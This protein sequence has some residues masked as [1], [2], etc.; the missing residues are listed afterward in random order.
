MS[1]NNKTFAT[2]VL[3]SVA[4]VMTITAL[5]LVS[6]QSSWDGALLT[7]LNLDSS[8]AA[9]TAAILNTPDVWSAFDAASDV[10][11]SDWLIPPAF[12]APTINS[13]NG[14]VPD[15]G[16]VNI[17][18][19]EGSLTTLSIT[20][21]S[22]STIV[23]DWLWQTGIPP[24]DLQGLN[25]SAIT[26]TA[27]QV[28]EDV[29]YYLTV[30]V[31]D[32]DTYGYASV[33]IDLTVLDADNVTNTAPTV[34]AGPDLPDATRGEEIELSG[35]TATDAETTD[36]LTYLWTVNPINAVTFVNATVLNPTITV[37]DTA[38]AG[39][40][41]LTLTVNDGT[42]DADDTRTF[43]VTVSTNTPPNVDAGPDLPDATRGDEI[44]LTE[45]TATDAETT[46][47]L[48]Y[49]WTVNPINAVTFVNATVLNPTITVADDATA[50]LVTLTLTV[51]DGTVDV[52][53]MRTFTVQ[54]NV[55]VNAEPTIVVDNLL[56]VAIGG[57][58]SPNPT[59][60][61]LD[62]PTDH[63]YTWTQS[64]PNTVTFNN[65]DSLMTTITAPA[66]AIAGDVT[67]T[68]T[69][70]DGE[71]TVEREITLTI[72]DP[73]INLAPTVDVVLSLT[74]TDSITN[75]RNL[76]L[77][78]ATGITTF[79]SDGHIYAAVAADANDG[80]QIL[81]VTDPYNIIAA[82][83]IVSDRGNAMNLYNAVGITTFKLDGH[84]YAAVATF[85]DSVQILNVTNPLNITATDSIRDAGILELN[86]A[87]DIT[88]FKSGGHTYAAVAAYQDHGV[89]ILNVTNPLNITPTD[90]ITNTGN[91]TLK[92]ARGVT[93]F[94]SGGHTYAAVAAFIDNGVQ[95]LNVTNPSNITA[96]DRILDGGSLELEG[97]WGITTFKS[98]GHIYAAVAAYDDNGVQILNVTNP[99]NI[100][101]AG[102]IT[103]TDLDLRGPKDITTF[104]SGGHTYAAVALFSGAS[105]Q[106]LDVTNPYNITAVA[107]IISSSNTKLDGV[108]GIATFESRGYTYMVVASAFD[109]AVQIIRANIG[110]PVITLEGDNPVTISV[111]VTY[112]DKGATCTD[113]IEGIITMLPP[114]STVNT[115]S[116]GTYDVTYSCV[117]GEGNHA[118]DVSRRVTVQAESNTNTPP[119]VSA[120]PDREVLE[121][122][123]ITLTGATATDPD[124]DELTY[125][126]TSDPTDAV[127]FN[128]TENS[129]NPSVTAA[130]G[131]NLDSATLTL[132]VN[133]G[134][135]D[136]ADDMM[137]TLSDVAVNNPPIVEAGPDR[138]VLEGE[139]ITLTGATAT[140]P[141]GDELTYA[142][143]SDPT[144]AVNFNNTENSLNPSVTAAPGTNLDSA[145]LTLTV[146]DGFT[147]VADDMMLTL[148]DVAVNNPPIVEAGPDREVLEGESITLTGATATDPDGDELTYAWTSDPTDAVNFNNT[149]N[150]L[151]PSVTA[152]PGTNLD[153]ATLTLTV[154]DGFTDV[155]DDMMLTLSDVAVNNPPIVEAGPDR[156]VLEGE[157]IT[158]TGATA[159]DPD[160][161]EL[162]YAWTSDPTDAVNFNNTEN[163]LNPSVTAAPGTN[164]DSAT[165][166]LTVNDG[167]TDVAD[168]MML[169]LSDVAVNNPPIVEAGPDREVL[170]G[171]SI[172]L[173]GATATDPDGDELTY[174]WTSDPTDAVNFNNTEN[175]LNPSVTAA[176]GTNLD[177][178]TLTLTVNDGFTDVADDM[179][180]TLSDVAVN[181][182]PIVEAG[183]DREVLEGES[184]TLT[185][186]TATD[187]DGDELTYAWT[188]DPT[189][190]VNFNNTENSLNPSVTAAP[191]TNLDSATLTLTVNDG[192]TDVADDMMLTLSD[193][194]VNNPPIVEAGPDREVLEGE[195][196]TLTGATA[197]DPDGD[198]LTYAWTSD[199]TDAVNFNNTE[200][201]LNPSVTAA[202]GT[203][204][205]SATLTLTVNDGFT[206]VADDMMLTL[207]DVAVNNP[208]IVEAG[209]D[210]EVLEGESITLTGATATDP[211]GDE[212][213]YA[214]TSDPTDAV[215]FNNTENSL[216]PSVTAAPG[217][218]L[219]SATLTLTVNDG[220]TDV[221][222]D[223]MLTLSDVAVN[224]PPIVEAGPDREVLEGES[225]TLTGATATDPDGD[226][227]TYAWTS[228]P[229]DAVNF[230]NTE[231]SLNPSVTAAPGTNLDSATLTL[232]VNDGF[233]DVADDMML[234]LSDVAVNNPP[235]VEAG[236]DREVL[237]GESITLTG[238]TAT[239][240]DGDGLTY[241]W[242][243]SL[244]NTVTITNVDSLRPSITAST[245]NA[246]TTVTLTLTV[247]DETN[248][249]VSDTMELTIINF[250]N[251]PPTVD[252]GP[253]REVLEGESITLS[254]S[255]TDINE[256][257]TLSYTWSVASS[258]IVLDV[259][260]KERLTFTA[261]GVSTDTDYVFTLE[262][263]DG[264]DP[265]TDT[266]T[267]TVRNVP[268]SVLDA[269]YNP[270]NGQ[271]TITF[272]QDID[273]ADYTNIHIRG[274]GSDGITLSNVTDTSHLGRT[275]TAILSTEQ[276]E[277][278]AGLTGP[279]LD[280]ASGAVTDTDDD[281]IAQTSDF[282]I[283][284]LQ[285]KKSSSSSAPIVDLNTLA[286]AR[287]VEIPSVISEQ[288]SSHNAADPLEP[289]LRNDTFDFPLTINDYYYLLDDTTNTLTPRT[290]TAGQST[291]I[292][293]IVYTSKD[294]AHFTLYLNL[295]DDDANY[296]NS[297][298]YITY[299]NGG[300]VTVTD[301]HGYIADATITVTEEDDSM[302]EKKTVTI[303]I[304]FGEEPMGPTNMVAYM[305]NTDRRATIINLIDAIDVTAAAE[306][307]QN[308]ASTDGSSKSA[309]V[310]SEPDASDDDRSDGRDSQ[311]VIKSGIV[312][313]GDDDDA[314]TLSLIR[315]WSGFASESITDAELLESLN[316]DY[317]D[318]YIPN[319]VM[320]DLGAM[321]SK[322]SVTTD[323]FV[324]A[325]TY[326]LEM[327]TA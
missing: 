113:D 120:G 270:G 52:S 166:T 189:D 226:E 306:T 12:A 242:T 20:A 151:N 312:V 34:N 320:T 175:S 104:E 212:L 198:E 106:M 300:T 64:P 236:P 305:W 161:D 195:S 204:L 38:T 2:A 4:V 14:N 307:R 273:T 17:S 208:P 185:G 176:P 21:T 81:N 84:T 238:A 25:T 116:V 167:F 225:I 131:T 298:T 149:E 163:S 69:V 153:S 145:T 319:W 245:V 219:D 42:V 250:V 244:V 103:D 321:V 24:A 22:N 234:T 54:V 299:T 143:T 218:N 99:L 88:T 10:M 85:D 118:T 60:N 304:E 173:T 311:P 200:N 35:A 275:I 61:D 122:E 191:G 205:D 310:N 110:S 243:Q 41:T 1:N 101:A 291:E 265:N 296:A 89:Q 50:G 109:N 172:T 16:F 114:I 92:G 326:V 248:P 165:L 186:A 95:I 123:S 263:T 86:S 44:P 117:D 285:K 136:V 214:W 91:L 267:V 33:A 74:A 139:S 232:T 228:D 221:A 213:T 36:V 47:V 255:A 29:I 279:H 327:L 252:A 8:L 202:P 3:T 146:N 178:A 251:T 169:T 105:V 269:L 129:L 235:I 295:Q 309:K 158:L 180:L 144:D 168:D 71:H 111:G 63:V 133:D 230:N 79:E 147:D 55:V 190:A 266:V 253:D 23:Y 231:N 160:G 6:P 288:V 282:D 94:E 45:A 43:T 260:N 107:N 128:N 37:S 98:D 206:D 93:T 170:E 11:S 184:I 286:N 125:A 150:S 162:T 51:N 181:N 28:D 148:S 217:T 254:G 196:I 76:V 240:P 249:T 203:N 179:M 317:P 72:F 316:L 154:N 140:D 284:V 80:V 315:M 30:F 281:A 77:E 257:Y 223:M 53:D 292:E 68:L 9:V 277:T 135:T 159:T 308:S 32:D 290:V 13:I 152:A 237:E 57:M 323:E 239:D 66:D 97:A 164:L 87:S 258:D 262:V 188:S 268:I 246:N 119:Q 121:G 112:S 134:F 233:T 229:T 58:V 193:V 82:G 130:P 256:H 210:R 75:D 313:V 100:T 197:T 322:G 289:I 247:D 70:V 132:T 294:L 324:T 199:P 222:D 49:L 280:I 182:P 314:Q 207:S 276:K 141:D 318:T 227:L 78:G 187:P 201:S 157:S 48:T 96:T 259:V 302:P 215:N 325:L 142:W 303:T 274:T 224:N 56:S 171:E 126:W 40:V 108:S 220:F 39:M 211:D 283:R 15:D 194:A 278:Y 183:P 293:F 264:E 19:T 127:N 73:D 271:L 65:T 241:T 59:V 31:N 261:P 272:N 177:S 102:S 115:A 124:G 90:Q 156:E 18:T 62:G 83:S 137:L 155:A 301:P 67:L 297:D 138:E 216:N 174:A 7:D 26:F 46:D 209:P 27:P 287:I 5:S 192:F